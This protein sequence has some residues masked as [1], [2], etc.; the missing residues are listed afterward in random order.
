M[1]PYRHISGPV[2]AVSR[3]PPRPRPIA[4]DSG[5]WGPR[6]SARWAPT[7]APDCRREP[8]VPTPHCRNTAPDAAL[9]ELRSRVEADANTLV[10]FLLERSP[11]W[12]SAGV[13]DTVEPHRSVAPGARRGE[14]GRCLGNQQLP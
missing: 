7:S 11:A 8:F 9:T 13:D 3:F 10:A 4:N 2:P 1:P 12:D 14:R 6:P 5:A